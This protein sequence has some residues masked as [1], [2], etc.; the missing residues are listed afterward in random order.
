MI[1]Y[2]IKSFAKNLVMNVFIILQ[3]AAVMLTTVAMISNIES[4]YDVY[5]PF[6]GLLDGKGEVVYIP[7]G[8]IT[9]PY[10]L[11]N[12]LN[13]LTDIEYSA[14]TY[15]PQMYDIPAEALSGGY[16]YSGTPRVLAYDNELLELYLPELESGSADECISGMSD[17]G[18]KLKLGTYSMS[19]EETELDLNVSGVLSDKSKLL[20]S[21]KFN[22]LTVG[23][24]DMLSTYYRALDAG[25]GR[26]TLILKSDDLKNEGVLLVPSGFGIVRYNDNISQEAV[27]S[28]ERILNSVGGYASF[29]KVRENTLDDIYSQLLVIAPIIIML[30]LTVLLCIVSTSAIKAKRQMQG[31]A[32]F[33]LCGARRGRL[34]LIGLTETAVCVITALML[35]RMLYVIAPHLSLTSD[36]ILKT[37][38]PVIAAVILIAL[39]TLAA[40]AIISFVMTNRLP[41]KTQLYRER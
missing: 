3:L 38:F 2:G 33:A 31:Y 35:S 22:T 12:I 37:D 7:T 10:Q 9:N 30:V 8:K 19:G 5:R 32:I 26:N 21:D 34:F 25:Q 16:S 41:I 36:L 20:A 17:I 28:N 40:S 23:C 27:E 6:E 1:G 13:S 24:K 4:R 39:L 11:E 15:T 29:Q 18:D 14:F